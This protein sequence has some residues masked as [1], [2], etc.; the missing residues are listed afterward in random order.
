MRVVHNYSSSAEDKIRF[1]NPTAT[2]FSS[3]QATVS[4]VFPTVC[5][6]RAEF[7]NFWITDWRIA[8]YYS[9]LSAR[10]TAK[11]KVPRG[12]LFPAVRDCWNAHWMNDE[13]SATTVEVSILATLT[14][15]INISSVSTTVFS[16]PEKTSH[17]PG[18]QTSN[19]TKLREAA[20]YKRTSIYRP[21]IYRQ[22]WYTAPPYIA[23]HDIPP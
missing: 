15:R 12:K 7:R 4:Q 18:N 11:L 2:D 16:R 22:T 14:L 23:K 21:S 17:Q 19:F 6:G 10:P 5:G 20:R 8:E 1:F 3:K 13:K 9:L